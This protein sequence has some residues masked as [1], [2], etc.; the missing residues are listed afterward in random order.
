MTVQLQSRW[1]ATLNVGGRSFGA[2][3][4]F[5]GGHVTAEAVSSRPPAAEFARK[6]GSEKEIAEITIG[7]DY[8][9]TVDTDEAMAYLR[10]WV[11]I[12]DAVTVNRRPLDKDR[13]PYG[14]GRT[15]TGVLTAVNEPESDTNSTADKAQLTLTIEPANVSG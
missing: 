5:A 15:W 10:R 2:F 8:D 9:I 11:R 14:K 12:E 7:R 4:T 1:L 3:M 13:N 6:G